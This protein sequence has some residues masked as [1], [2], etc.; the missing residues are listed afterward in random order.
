MG[1]VN[2]EEPRAYE[3][4]VLRAVQEDLLRVDAFPRGEKTVRDVFLEGG[5]PETGLVVTFV[6]TKTNRE[7]RRTYRL[8]Q[9]GLFDRGDGHRIDPAFADTLIYTN[10]LEAEG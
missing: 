7:D 1:E 5:Y 6:H 10:I 2:P 3:L 8:W 4:A 9:D